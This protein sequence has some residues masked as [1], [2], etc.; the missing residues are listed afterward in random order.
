M[1]G[2]GLVGTVFG[3]AAKDL[4][5]QGQ[6]LVGPS[7]SKI[8]DRELFLPGGGAIRWFGVGDKTYTWNLLPIAFQIANGAMKKKEPL[9]EC[10]ESSYLGTAN[11]M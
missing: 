2:F 5:L 6:L 1:P 11:C 3:D 10:T 4:L 9:F 7:C 8:W